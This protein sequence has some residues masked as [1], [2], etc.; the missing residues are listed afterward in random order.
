[1]RRLVDIDRYVGERIRERRIML[2]VTLEQFAA[3]VGVSFQQA[4]KYEK[5]MNRVS[6][7]RLYQIAQALDTDVGYFFEGAGKGDPLPSRQQRLFLELAR[8][9]I[10]IPHLRYQEEVAALARA[11]AESDAKPPSL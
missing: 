10:A 11:L 6:A 4:Y 3:L 7:G 5:G 2:G 8:N 9:F 1:M